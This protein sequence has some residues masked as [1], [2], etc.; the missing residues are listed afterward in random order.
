ML[1]CL[2]SF[3]H[4]T[5]QNLKN[6]LF[7]FSEHGSDDKHGNGNLFHLQKLT[8]NVMGNNNS[9]SEM[10]N[11]KMINMDVFMRKSL[12]LSCILSRVKQNSFFSKEKQLHM[13][14]SS[15]LTAISPCFQLCTSFQIRYIAFFFVV[16]RQD[17][18]SGM[19]YF[20]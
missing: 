1:T 11:T 13:S 4:G 3:A 5:M 12:Y 10:R 9:S 18:F 7:C 14:K 19:V 6:R 17:S 2:S 8:R 16:L 15:Y 20:Y